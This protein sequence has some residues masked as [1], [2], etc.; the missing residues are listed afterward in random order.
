MLGFNSTIQ[1]PSFSS[2]P[3]SWPLL[4]LLI[5]VF[6]LAS[7]TWVTLYSAVS[8]FDNTLIVRYLYD[9]RGFLAF[10]LRRHFCRYEADDTPQ[11]QYISMHYILQAR[12]EFAQQNGTQGPRVIVSIFLHHSFKISIFRSLMSYLLSKFETWGSLRS[13]CCHQNWDKMCGKNSYSKFSTRKAP[14]R[15]SVSLKGVQKALPEGISDKANQEL[16]FQ[17]IFSYTERLSH[18]F[19]IP[20]AS[21]PLRNLSIFFLSH[22]F[23]SRVQ[24]KSW[25]MVLEIRMHCWRTFIAWLYNL[26]QVLYLSA[27]HKNFKQKSLILAICLKQCIRNLFESNLLTLFHFPSY[28]HV[29]EFS[30]ISTLSCTPFHWT[31]NLN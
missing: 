24:Y 1:I 22:T 17:I 4:K 31:W 23:F 13:S 28:D 14:R 2:L 26:L 25:S 3:L 15:K 19:Q 6:L 8:S 27:A 30:P 21:C 12:R 16:S 10:K 7:K 5:V 29:G 18:S 20:S 11:Q 9:W